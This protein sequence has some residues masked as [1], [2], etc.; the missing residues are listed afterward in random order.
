MRGGR[1][2]RE[3][4]KHEDLFRSIVVWIE[5]EKREGRYDENES[6]RKRSG[7]AGVE[8]GIE[9]RGGGVGREAPWTKGSQCGSTETE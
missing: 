3:T 4:R 8:R 7:C 9:Q 6:A 5:I 2:V 1:D